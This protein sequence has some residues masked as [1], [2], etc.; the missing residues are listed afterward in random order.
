MLAEIILLYIIV[1][2]YGIV[3]GSFVNVLIYRLP[4]HENIATERSHCMS[5][6]H[7]LRWYDLVPLFSWLLLRGKCRYCKARIS[8]QYPIVEAV[9][10]FGYV[11]ILLVDGMNLSSILYMLCFSIL[12]AVAVIDWRTYEIPVG[13]N[14]AIL[15]LGIAAT[16]ADY[17]NVW[18]HL[19]GM[20]SVSGFLLLLYIITRGRGIGG[21]DIKLMGAAGLLLGWKH[22]I[23]ALVIGCIVG[24]VIHIVLMKVKGKDRVLAFGPYLA[25]GLFAV[26]LWGDRMI[27]WYTGLFM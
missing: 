22:I 15:A 16:V 6:G 13:L 26:M 19:I 12:T 10:G 2:A 3:V 9:N 21:G 17:R 11:L 1:F 27:S 23:F 5:C 4:K 18:Y 14:I 24:S 7:K 20:V 8:A 25:A